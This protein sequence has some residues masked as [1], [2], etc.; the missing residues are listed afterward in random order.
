MIGQIDKAGLPNQQCVW[1]GEKG[2][3]KDFKNVIMTAF[4]FD[5]K[6]P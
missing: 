4:L 1:G 3:E 5:T 2:E 6:R